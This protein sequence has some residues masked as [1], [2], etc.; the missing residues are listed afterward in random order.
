[1]Q[2]ARAFTA[3]AIHA[4]RLLARDERIP[5]PL[6][7]LVLIGLLPIPGPFDEALLLLAAPLL[8]IFAGEP[9]RDAWRRAETERFAR[10]S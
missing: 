6:R 5:K 2:K 3:R 7:W 8:F 1:M 9:M 10:P 4:A